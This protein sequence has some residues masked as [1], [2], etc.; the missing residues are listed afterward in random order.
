MIGAAGRRRKV[1]GAGEPPRGPGSGRPPS[2]GALPAL[3]DRVSRCPV[4]SGECD[5]GGLCWG[6]GEGRRRPVVYRG[7]SAAPPRGEG[8]PGAE[9]SAPE[10]GGA[11]SSAR[12]GLREF[13]W[14]CPRGWVCA[15]PSSSPGRE[16]RSRCMVRER[17][18]S[19]AFRSPTCCWPENDFPTPVLTSGGEKRVPK[20]SALKWI[21]SCLPLA[22]RDTERQCR[23]LWNFRVLASQK[24]EIKL[25][26]MGVEWSSS[27]L[28]K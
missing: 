19:A 11:D 13:G 14:S 5:G 15:D 28:S 1:S 10:P 8:L 18:N 7:R 6:L 23:T 16:S 9:A 12:P 26:L 17:G 22:L 4:G 20:R 24:N 25:L 21:C 3:R 27:A 2:P